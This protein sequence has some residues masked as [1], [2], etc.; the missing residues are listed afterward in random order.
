MRSSTEAL[1]WLENRVCAA[2]RAKQQF[3]TVF[4]DLEKA[5][6]TV[7][8][9]GNLEALHSYGLRGRLPEFLTE[10]L[11]AGRSFRV[12]VGGCLFGARPQEEGVPQGSVLSVT[13]FTVGI[14]GIAS[15]VPDGV[16]STCT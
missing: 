1:T 15:A 10:F 9:K 12:R 8:R 11:A 6:D 14:N 4:F 13:L 3:V 16:L 7:W 5:Y 2:F